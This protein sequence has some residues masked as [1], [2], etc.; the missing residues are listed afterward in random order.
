MQNLKS[1]CAQGL[2]IALL[3]C[4]S[5]S[6]DS[7]G[8]AAGGSPA[9]GSGSAGT[10]GTAATGASGAPSTGDAGISS[11][12]AGATD[13]AGGAA[14]GSQSAAGGTTPGSGGAVAAS[15]SAGQA[16]SAGRGGMGAGAAGAAGEAGASAGLNCPAGNF[17]CESFDSYPTGAAPTGIWTK[18]TRGTG[19]IT[20]DATRSFTGSQSLHASGVLNGD[21]AHITTP[22]SISDKTVFVRFMMYTV[23]YPSSSGVH[24]R[25]ARLGTSADSGPDSAYSLSSYNGTAIEKVDSIYLR[26]TAVHLNDMAYKNRWFCLEFE[27]DKTGGAGKVVPQI[28]IDGAALTLA[29]AGSSTHAGTSTSWDPIP[30]EKFTIGLEGNQVDPVKGDYWLDDVII[31]AQRIG[32]PTK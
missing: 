18:T 9:G 27:I 30:F 31:A 7:L 10:G 23:G 19:S 16:A 21:V 12:F 14:V 2:F 22:L 15:G 6:V 25:L 20:V 26:S 13:S 5:A 28:W 3:G 32:C 11:N 24:S 4:S 1:W 17:L 29:A 8:A